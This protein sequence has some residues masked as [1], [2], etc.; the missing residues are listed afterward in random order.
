MLCAIYLVNVSMS[1]SRS[2]KVSNVFLLHIFTQVLYLE[3]SLVRSVIDASFHC[4]QK[5]T[6][7][8]RGGFLSCSLKGST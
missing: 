4:R 8:G 2:L 6:G 7:K 5:L 1:T 3:S